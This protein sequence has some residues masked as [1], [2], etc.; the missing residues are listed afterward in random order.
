MGSGSVLKSAKDKYGIE[1]FSKEILYYLSNDDEMYNKEKEIVNESFINRLDTYN[2]KVGG[3]G[4]CTARSQDSID[5][6]VATYNAKSEDEKTLIKE[7]RNNSL[8]GKTRSKKQK[9][10]MSKSQKGVSWEEKFGTIK[11]NELKKIQ[12]EKMKKKDAFFKGKKH[13]EESKK[14][15][16][17]SSKGQVF[18]EESKEKMREAKKKNPPTHRKGVSL[19]NEHKNKI[20][21]SLKNR[22][23]EVRL[24]AAKKMFKKIRVFNN[25]DDLVKHF[26]SIKEFKEYGKLEGWPTTKLRESSMNDGERIT[27]MKKNNM[28]KYIGWYA[29]RV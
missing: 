26:D 10:N 29:I 6:A 28:K 23:K 22:S 7:K 24:S 16:S 4:G 2:I 18:S 12:S 9:E 5:K 27:N 20:S 3:I 17:E 1:N 13:T 14:K 21:E 19:T 25:M 11:S 15:M 8:K